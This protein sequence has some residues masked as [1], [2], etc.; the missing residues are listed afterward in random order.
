MYFL[1][2]VIFAEFKYCLCTELL[3]SLQIML[4][5]LY[6]LFETYFEVNQVVLWG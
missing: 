3:I 1:F 5:L 2:E 4:D 6:K